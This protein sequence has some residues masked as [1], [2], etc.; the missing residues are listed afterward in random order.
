MRICIHIL[1][2]L[3]LQSTLIHLCLN[4]YMCACARMH[5]C[6]YVNTHTNTYI[7]HMCIQTHVCF[8]LFLCIKVEVQ[9]FID[10]SYN[11]EWAGQI[12][13]DKC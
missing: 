8:T 1:W 10:I 11:Q 6:M 2:V 4:V 9:T 13:A 5:V 7:Y 12:V 3:L